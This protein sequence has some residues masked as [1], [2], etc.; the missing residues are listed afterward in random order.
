MMKKHYKRK[1]FSKFHQGSV[2][3]GIYQKKTAT[4]SNKKK[5]WG[6]PY[7]TPYYQNNKNVFNLEQR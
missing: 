3:P 4:V 1:K 2:S 5:L 6:L 7:I